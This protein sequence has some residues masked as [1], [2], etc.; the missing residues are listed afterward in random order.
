MP[1]QADYEECAPGCPTAWI[2]DGVCDYYCSIAV[3]CMYDGNDCDYQNDKVAGE[4]CAPG[5]PNCQYVGDPLSLQFFARCAPGC[6]IGWVGD[7]F[8]DE[9]CKVSAECFNDG[10]DCATEIDQA[11]ETCAPGCLSV[12]VGNG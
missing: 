11:N 7:G 3:D 4:E 2:G 8:C 9:A 5:C 1:G 12:L 6:P 10:E